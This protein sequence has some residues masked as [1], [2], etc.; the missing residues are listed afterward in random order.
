MA[1]LEEWYSLHKPHIVPQIF[2]H[3]LHSFAGCANALWLHAGELQPQRVSVH[4]FS[5]LKLAFHVTSAACRLCADHGADAANLFL[6]DATEAGLRALGS[7]YLTHPPWMNTW[8]GNKAVLRG[9][10]T[11]RIPAPASLS[12]I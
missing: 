9:Q 12:L 7:Q 6:H 10:I 3:S 1:R 4:G 5:S 8:K 2:Y 11:T